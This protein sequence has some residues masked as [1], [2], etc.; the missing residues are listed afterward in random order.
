MSTS[1]KIE[2]FK[3]IVL[4]YYHT[5]KRILPWRE[6]IN[7][8]W[9]VISEIMLQQTQVSRVLIKFPEFIKK[10]PSFQTLAESSLTDVLS[11][12]RGMGY[13]RRAKY[14]RLISQKIVREYNNKIPEDPKELES[15][16]G[17]GPA[18]AGA[19]VTYIYN[20]PHIFI[21]TNIRRVIIHHFFHDKQD[22]TDREIVSFV[23]KTL[24]QTNPRDWYYALMD[25]GSYLAKQVS[26]PNR[27]SKHYTKQTKF[28]GSDRQIRGSLLNLLVQKHSLSKK[29]ITDLLLFEKPRVYNILNDLESEG[30]VK[31]KKGKYQIT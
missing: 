20:K 2:K 5:H 13:S 26:N 25:Y 10:F 7:P 4:N 22:V 9:V 15:F 19:I 6:T 21:E 27:R 11:V 29:E 3:Q 18:T 1:N 23:E 24:D 31:E 28:E 30:F 16:P 8:Y 14:L 12:W 17:I